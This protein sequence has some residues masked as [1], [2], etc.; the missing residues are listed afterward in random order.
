LAGGDLEESVR[1]A[2][3]DRWLASRFIADPAHRMATLAILAFD[4]ELARASLVTS[5]SLA[6]QIRLT[7]WREAIDEIAG[8]GQP[9]AHPVAKALAGAVEL[10]LDLNWLHEAIDARITVLDE[11]PLQPQAAIAFADG[12][13]GSIAVASGRLLDAQADVAALKSGGRVI[14]LDRLR[15]SRPESAETLSPLVRQ[16]LSSAR[17]DARRLKPLALPAVLAAAL[18]RAPLRLGPWTGVDRRIRLLAAMASGRL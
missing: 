13:A 12:A 8:G 7:W 10:G 5:S 4:L 6:A 2:D 16:A 9:R 1:R 15:R 18:A 11:P 3:P 17:A 14:G